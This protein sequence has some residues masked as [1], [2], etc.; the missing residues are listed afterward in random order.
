MDKEKI[1]LLSAFVERDSYLPFERCVP[2]KTLMELQIAGVMFS[3]ISK[4]CIISADTG[5]GKTIMAAALINLILKEKKA[6]FVV[7]RF[8]LDEIFKKMKESLRP[9]LTLGYI[10]DQEDVIRPM[11]RFKHANS[12]N[13]LIISSDAVANPEVNKYIFDIRDE[14]QV[15]FIDE[16]HLFAN[17]ESVESRLMA[18]L[19][20]H[21]EYAIPLSATP[22]ERDIQQLI[23]CCYYLDNNIYKGLSPRTFGNKFKVYDNGKLVGYKNIDVLK[24]I[25]SPMIFVANRPDCV[26]CVIHH[27][28]SKPQWR[29][30]RDVDARRII[31]LDSTGEPYYKLLALL[32]EYTSQGKKGIIYANFNDVKRML[33]EKLTATGYSVGVV[34]GT[35]SKELKQDRTETSYLFNVNHYQILITNRSVSLDQECDF[36]IMYEATQQYLQVIGRAKRTFD[37]RQVDVDIILAK[38]TYDEEFFMNNVYPKIS[39]IATILDKDITSLKQ[40]VKG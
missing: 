39:M 23:D 35:V 31:K 12:C 7:K 36:V 17:F 14:I 10:T 32:H 40:A 37:N 19:L 25:L 20:E 26:R 18:K 15:I 34:D 24:R 29:K 6:L 21:C 3:I 13:V 5:Y 33:Y 27:V 38:N 8:T 30:L 9:D 16:I 28:T 11:V 4:K 2:H 22:F 1:E